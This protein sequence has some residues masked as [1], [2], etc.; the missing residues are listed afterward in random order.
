MKFSEMPYKRPDLEEAKRT[1]TSLTGTLKAADSFFKAD[2]VFLEMEKAQAEFMTMSTLAYIRHSI[3]TRDAFYEA[4]KEF[5]NS[6]EPELEEYQQQWMLTLLDNPFRPQFEEKFGKLYFTN[7]E[8]RLKT[9][10]PEIIPELQRENALCTEYDKL[11]AS[12]QIPFEGE[13]YTIA[14]MGPY[15]L[16]PD[17]RRR[18]SAWKTEA[19]LFPSS[20]AW[21]AWW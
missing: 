2:E 5:F 19:G 11:L 9:F 8:M 17:D 4:E 16:D 3:D 20:P 15:K 18:L 10:S 12:A 14:Q 21:G 6:A 7:A 13:V 1:I